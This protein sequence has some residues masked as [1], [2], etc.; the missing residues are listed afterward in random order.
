MFYI[1]FSQYKLRDIFLPIGSSYV[2]CNLLMYGILVAKSA[3]SKLEVIKKPHRVIRYKKRF[4]E[5]QQIYLDMISYF[6][7]IRSP[8]WKSKFTLAIFVLAKSKTYRF[9]LLT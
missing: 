6:A 8:L 1:N 2:T 5:V 9:S 3:G 4:K 7:K